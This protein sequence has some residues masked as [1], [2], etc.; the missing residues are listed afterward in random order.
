MGEVTYDFILDFKE[1]EGAPDGFLNFQV[2]GIYC[3]YAGTYDKHDEKWSV[4]TLLYIGE[5]KN[6]QKRFVGDAFDTLLWKHSYRKYWQQYLK[7]GENL[8]YVVAKFNGED[9]LRKHVEAALIFTMRPR[10]N[11]ERIGPWNY[12]FEPFYSPDS[13][14]QVTTKGDWYSMRVETQGMKIAERHEIH[15]GGHSTHSL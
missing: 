12:R 7:K 2:P 15:D 13:Y 14:H 10:Y 1:V 4:R 3:V 11:D 5:S 9:Y 6:V 8:L